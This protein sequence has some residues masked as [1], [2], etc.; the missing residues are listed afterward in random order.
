MAR[1]FLI[2]QMFRIVPFP[3]YLFI[4]ILYCYQKCYR[5]E[6]VSCNILINFDSD[7]MNDLKM[8][9][10]FYSLAVIYY[11]LFL[12]KIP[13]AGSFKKSDQIYSYIYQKYGMFTKK[14]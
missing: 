6:S 1:T 7:D 10:N 9:A 8:C 5:N 11:K 2:L 3:L 4:Y 13:E 14:I 12:Y